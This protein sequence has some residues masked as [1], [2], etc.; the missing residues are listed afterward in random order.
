LVSHQGGTSVPTVFRSPPRSALQTLLGSSSA[1]LV[2]T[3]RNDPL[4]AFAIL[5][6][7]LRCA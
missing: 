5:E 2:E 3:T 6:A 4:G 7:L 1:V